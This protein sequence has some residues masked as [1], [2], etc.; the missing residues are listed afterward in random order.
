MRDPRITLA[1][2]VLALVV[3]MLFA[4]AIGS[5][6]IPLRFL[7]D[8]SNPQFHNALVVGRLPRVVLGAIAGGGLAA[9]GVAFQATLRNPLAEPFLLGVSGGC[10]L[11]ATL[12][13]AL[14]AAPFTYFGASVVPLAAL[15]GGA[16][17]T[18]IVYA[19]VRR[20]GTGDAHAI[21]LAGVVLN[22][23][24]GSLIT[25]IRTL[26]PAGKVQELTSWLTG[27]LDVQAWPTIGFV[28]FY[29]L[30][31]SALL[32]RLSGQ[33]NLLALGNEGATHLGVNVKKLERRTF[34]AGSL[35]VGA[36]VSVTGLI[37]W[38]GLLV[39]HTMRKL[40]GPDVRL[41][42]P[43]SF[44]FG[45]A[46]LVACD[47]LSRFTFQLGRELPVGAVTALLGGPLFLVLM[48]RRPEAT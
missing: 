18:A 2:S 36:I 11:G 38:I 26:V 41:L 5:D 9:S 15:L 48:V 45:G 24:A 29:T 8:N 17:S 40:L 37:G 46:T 10:A 14:G 6:S 31:G 28:A 43:T 20:W 21:I 3:A 27:F 25:F 42:L 4:V 32:M 13:I 33:L 12:A 34:L 19:V 44:F 1:L 16:V 47:A 7:F 30:I 23:I 35:I 39:P 22:A